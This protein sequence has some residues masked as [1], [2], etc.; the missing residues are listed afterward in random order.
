MNQ[1]KKGKHHGYLK[2]RMTFRE[3]EVFCGLSGI[4][5]RSLRSDRISSN[6]NKRKL[7]KYSA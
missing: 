4:C 3:I 5:V 1:H 7:A 6:R 2:E